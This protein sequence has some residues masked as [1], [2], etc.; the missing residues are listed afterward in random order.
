[1]PVPIKRL[2]SKY[3][4]DEKSLKAAFDAST[5]EERPKVK[6]LVSGI[7]EKIRGGID[8]NRTDY[9]LFK[10][11]DWG[12]DSPFYQVSYTQLRGLLTSGADDKKVMETVN[13]WG[14]THLLPDVIGDDGQPCCSSPGV[15]QKSLNL[16]VFFNI[17]VP[18]CMAY[19]SI[20]WAKLFN[21]RDLVPLYKY[22][23]VQFTKQ[24]RI[25]CEIITQAVQRMSSW[26]DYKAD[27]KQ[28]IL[29]TLLYGF[30][31]NFP[32]E[33]WHSEKQED[34]KGKE[35]VMREGLRFNMPHPSRTYYD[36][37]HR[38]SSLNSNS[39]CDYAGYWGIKKYKDI[40]DNPLYWNKDKISIGATSWFDLG[41]SDF[42]SQVFPCVMTFPAASS[43]GAAGVGEI[44][45][46]SAAARFYGDGDKESATLETQHFERI[47]P[48]DCGL[49]T[50]KHPV[51][52]R[53]VMA[54]DNAVLWAEPLPFD[55]LPT[56][57]YDADFNRARFRSLALEI[58]PFQ[59][60]IGNLMSQWIFAVKENLINPIFF[61]KD[62]IPSEYMKSIMNMGQK[63]VGGRNF[64]PFSA[65]ENARF[66]KID[67]REAFF[68]PQ[69]AR[70]DTAQI[71][72]VISGV[73][74]MLDRIMQLSPQEIGQAASHEQTAEES[75]IIARNTST[76][77][78]F[79]GSFIDD[80]EYAKKVM[81]YDAMMAYADDEITVGI[82][83]TI[84]K[85]EAEFQEI[86]KELGFTM[87]ESSSDERNPAA[88]R[89]VTVKKSDLRIE[90]FASTRDGQDRIDNPAIAD[91]MSKIFIAI[92]G[93]PVL[94]QSIGVQQLVELLNQIIVTA[95][96]PKEFK[97]SGKD[98][99]PTA[100]Q[101]DQASQLGELMTGFSE[102]VKQAIGE[103]QQA[104]L[105]ASAAQTQEMIKAA[106]T[107]VA[108]PISQLA[109]SVAQSSQENQIQQK[110]IDELAAG[111]EQLVAGIAAATTASP[112]A[113]A[114]VAPQ[115]APSFEPVGVVPV[116]TPA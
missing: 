76:R 41:S 28:T 96:L 74:D 116:G 85:D 105:E 94:I 98:I 61:D 91:A 38:L 57:A 49:G 73:L 23:P 19:I 72:S 47:I 45:R 93:N 37:F 3:K 44:D 101:E 80:G 79:T 65:T 36:P 7:S 112:A 83:S 27:M 86:I 77:V 11:M 95:G 35:K 90:T 18:I 20:R 115:V 78:A 114:P 59:D 103:S 97:L 46:E 106:I 43:G 21:D 9:R 25:K 69:F 6:K 48:A 111:F 2:K 14:L 68:S 104:T 22:E 82:S 100:S 32:R 84:A 52:F 12:Y 50:Y 26:F 71:A 92:S 8:R 66:G 34:D 5:I 110:Q 64:V 63:I 13:S 88:M 113:P 15:K 17:F 99:D 24:N 81:L 1:M 75:R 42:L 29:Q 30:C 16:P 67:Q 89:E 31:I 33:S 102:Q 40:K 109:E 53:F 39:G 55:R 54:S 4:L 58:V 51:W 10:A 108:E 56:Y 62:K 107:Q 70:H 87:K 60:H